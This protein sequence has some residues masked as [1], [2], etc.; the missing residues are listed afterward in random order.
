MFGN[1][2]V[3]L[4]SSLFR[5][6][7]RGSSVKEAAATMHHLETDAWRPPLQVR[8]TLVLLLRWSLPKENEILY[9]VGTVP[10]LCA[11]VIPLPVR[12]FWEFLHIFNN[13][14]WFDITFF[15]IPNIPIT[16]KTYFRIENFIKLVIGVVSAKEDI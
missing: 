13:Y 15:F 8:K 3:I 7:S 1:L 9:F 11:C 16:S 2:I 6:F 14:S 12:S 4:T 5:V 10:F